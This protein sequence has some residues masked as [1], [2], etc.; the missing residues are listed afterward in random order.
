MT[1]TLGQRVADRV[2]GWIGSWPF[3]ILQTSLLV[4]WIYLNEQP[5]AWDRYPF[6]LLNLFLSLQ[7]AYLGPIILIATNRQA[8]QDRR[9]AQDFYRAA[10][11]SEALL[12]ELLEELRD[13]AELET[14]GRS[15][16]EQIPLGD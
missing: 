11:R 2:A 12:Q 8:H 6:I 15:L 16:T 3:L 10:H 7:S 14:P 1:P 5:H 13:R 9:E 4:S